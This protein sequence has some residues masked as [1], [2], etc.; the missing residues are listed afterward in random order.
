LYRCDDGEQQPIGPVE[1][2]FGLETQ[3]RRHGLE[4]MRPLMTALGSPHLSYPT[5]HVAGSKGKGSTVAML[6]AILRAAGY[7]VGSYTSPSLAHFGERIQVHG[8]TITDAECDRHLAE[9]RRALRG[10]EGQPRFFEAATAIAFR[11][12]AEEAVD[13]AVIE[14]GM[15]GERDATNVVLPEV[16]VITSI[17]LEHTQ[18]LGTTLA[19]IAREKAGIV[20]PLVP[21]VT[22]VSDP[23]SL[24]PIE[25]ACAERGAP[26][27]RLERD[28]ELG[29][30]RSHLKDQQFDLCSSAGLGKLR[31][32]AVSLNLAG[33][34]QCSNAALAV[35]AAGLLS[36]RLHRVS[37]A[38]IRQGLR[39]VQWP[40]R[41]ELREGRPGVLL[42]VAHTPDSAAQLRRYLDRFFANISKTLV[43]GMLR[44]KNPDALAAELAPAFDHVVA[45]P[46]KWHRSM[47]PE[48]VQRAFLAYCDA[49]ELAPSISAGVAQAI[50]TSPPHGLVVVA[51][52]VFAVGETTRRFGWG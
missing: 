38:A 18:I 25:Q 1:R 51:G 15:G 43:I 17:E 16:A 27:W 49:V 37:E 10:I 26:L 13:V 42:D 8:K 45:A 48:D 46:V 41:L 40:G 28:F 52:S 30:V 14:V 31:L 12:F 7:R 34:A 5:V 47:D 50:R 33:E 6:S 2:E 4:L 19:A 36:S 11:H 22:A 24:G 35:V 20:K 29:H 39:D 32:D 44:D 23:E 3:V 21:T 9:L